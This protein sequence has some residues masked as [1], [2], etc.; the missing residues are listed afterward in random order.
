MST[1]DLSSKDFQEFVAFLLARDVVADEQ[2]FHYF[3]EDPSGEPYDE[4]VLSRPE[5]IVGHMTRLFSEFGRIAPKYSLSPLNR[6]MWG[7]FGEKLRLYEL[8]WDSSIPLDQRIQCIRSM[9]FQSTGDALHGLGH[10]HQPAVRETVQKFIDTH[11]GALTE[12]GLRWLEQ[13][14]DGTVM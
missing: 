7:I 12:Q 10:L 6:G 13:C 8:L 1:L 2:Q 5:V 3:L 14:R 9:Y 4:A 11:Q